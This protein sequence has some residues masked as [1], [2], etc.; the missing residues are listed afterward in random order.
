MLTFSSSRN[1]NSI[2]HIFTNPQGRIASNV[3]S[4]PNRPASLCSI[5]SLGT[6][7]SSGNCTFHRFI[8][9]TACMLVCDNCK[10]YWDGN[11]R[12]SGSCSHPLLRFEHRGRSW[13]SNAGVDVDSKHKFYYCICLTKLALLLLS[14]ETKERKSQEIRVTI[15]FNSRSR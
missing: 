11:L 6:S 13:S 10:L 14:R 2:C 5:S 1:S 15:M 12:Y 9:H 7:V 8:R 3:W 4:L